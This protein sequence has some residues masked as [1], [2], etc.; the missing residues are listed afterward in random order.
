MATIAYKEL[1]LSWNS[2]RE[3]DRKFKI[4]TV[5]SMVLLFGIV[6]YIQSIEVPKLER[7][8]H[9]IPDRI[10]KFVGQAPKPKK[11]EVPKPKLKPK[12]IPKLEPKP[13]VEKKVEKPKESLKKKL[14]KKQKPKKKPLTNK[15]KAAREKAQKSGLL[16]LS[17]GLADLMDTSDISKVVVVNKGKKIANGSHTKAATVSKSLLTARVSKNS[18]GVSDADF[19]SDVGLTQTELEVLQHSEVDSTLDVA[20]AET[21]ASRMNMRSEEEITMVFDRNKSKLFSIYN[22]ERRTDPGLKGTIVLEIV[23]APSGEVVEVRIV[24]SELNNSKLERRILS[25]IK[26]FNFGEKE[27]DTVTVSYPIEFIPS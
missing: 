4:I 5:I 25:R 6:F 21:L 13:K 7:K 1:A 9:V 19:K 12:P 16:E 22:R 27:V 3:D 17:K 15:Q 14:A 18:G 23:I 8:A 26:Q 10:A 2:T 24:S 20:Q 11:I